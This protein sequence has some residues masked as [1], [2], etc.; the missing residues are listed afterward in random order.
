MRVSGRAVEPLAKLRLTPTRKRTM[1]R[2]DG[3][4]MSEEAPTSADTGPARFFRA[5]GA[6]AAR[7]A[8]SAGQSLVAAYRSIDADV[9]RHLAELPLLGLVSLAARRLPAAA[10]PDDGHRPVIFVH[11]L[12]GYR[13]NFTP[14][15]L[16]LRLQ[17]RTRTY[18]VGFPGDADL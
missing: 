11:G 13:G 18:A 14:A 1:P 12:G 7:A 10:L 6:V 17:G 4:R 3:G 8:R 16:F 9:P 2:C 15:R 5:F